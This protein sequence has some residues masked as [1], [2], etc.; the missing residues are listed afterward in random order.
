MNEQRQFLEAIRATPEDPGLRLVFADWLDDAGKETWASLIRRQVAQ[1][2]SDDLEAERSSEGWTLDF[3]RP[4]SFALA[5]DVDFTRLRTEMGFPIDP[6]PHLWHRGFIRQLQ[7]DAA[8]FVEHGAALLACGPVPQVSLRNVAPTLEAL[9]ACPALAGVRCLLLDSANLSTSEFETLLTSPYLSGVEE[10]RLGNRERRMGLRLSERVATLLGNTDSLPNL[11][12][13]RLDFVPLGDSGLVALMESSRLKGLTALSL[14]SVNFTPRPLRFLANTVIWP[15]LRALNVTGNAIVPA[16]DLFRS[17]QLA[18]LESLNAQCAALD[19]EAIALLARSP[20]A[21]NLRNL[22]LGWN[23]MTDA[24]VSSLASS[25][26][27]AG[28]RCLLLEASM[29]FMGMPRTTFTPRAGQLLRS[30]RFAP[31]L[32]FLGLEDQPLGD[33]GLSGLGSLSNFPKLEW[34]GLRGNGI[35]DQGIAELVKTELP[36]TLRGL[37]ISTNNIGPAGAQALANWAG[38]PEVLDCYMARNPMGIGGVE[39]FLSRLRSV[40]LNED[41]KFPLD[42]HRMFIGDEGLAKLLAAPEI[43][44]CGALRLH[45]NKLTTAS[46][47]MVA[48][49]SALAGL[50]E[51]DFSANAIQD[52]GAI[53]LAQSRY[54]SQ[55]HKLVFVTCG[56]TDAGAVAIIDSAFA[57]QLITLVFSRNHLSDTTARAFARREWPKLEYLQLDANGLTHEQAVLLLERFRGRIH[58]S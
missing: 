14:E 32:R 29:S 42:F 5:P 28:L 20:H 15:A 10:L 33:A 46:A 12:R 7:I 11:K 56:L 34:I 36:R 55:V 44:R 1:A 6:K 57:S 38:F 16:N 40:R 49:C 53:A 25:T 41:V 27:L 26:V 17:P 21:A 52:S 18:T 19:D 24:S 4:F 58:F 37:D 45:D 47:K 30:A 3:F 51:L 54:L 9:V 48:E 22:D 35:G 31:N 13:L 23:M 39:L 8:A 43:R 50:R 2:R